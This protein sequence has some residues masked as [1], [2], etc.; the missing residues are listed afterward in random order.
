MKGRLC[1]F[2]FT[3]VMC[4]YG[5]GFNSQKETNVATETPFFTV[6]PTHTAAVVETQPIIIET[7]IATPTDIIIRTPIPTPSPSPT[8][9]VVVR[10][11]DPYEIYLPSIALSEPIVNTTTVEPTKKPESKQKPTPTP[12]PTV[13]FAAVRAELLASGQELAFAKIGFHVGLGGNLNGLG[14]WMRRLDQAG[15][16]FFLKSVDYAGPI[17]EA[18]EMM[19]KSGVPHVLVYRSTG[20][21]P[22]YDLSPEEAARI[23]WEDHRNRFPPELDPSLVWFE[24]INEVDKNRSEWLAQFALATAQLS[25]AEGFKWAAFGWSSGEPEIQYWELPSMQSFL[26]LAGQHPDQ[27]AIA[28]HEY[29]FTEE[30]IDFE[31]PYRVG[32]FLH[33]FQ[34]CDQYGIPRPTVLITEWGW[35]YNS[36]PSVDRAL[37]HIEW[38]SKLYAPFPEVKGAAIWYLG[39]GDTFGNIADEAQKLIEPVMIF[40]LT[41]YYTMP[42]LPAQA[43]ANPALYGP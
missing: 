15:V 31:Y 26:R 29:S 8:I 34:I 18:Q 12:I 28:V 33:L 9:D 41:H 24:T 21:V 27:L 13:D 37:Q 30:Q 19:K 11:P 22:F 43:T 6:S 1:F 39:G 2:S 42:V 40:A 16:P 25:L 32:H 7:P 23:H 14:D 4:L 3:L 5:C 35:E 17:Y 20:D 10:A 38:A 36:V